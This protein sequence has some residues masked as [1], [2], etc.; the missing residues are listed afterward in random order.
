M[1]NTFNKRPTKIAPQV[2][3]NDLLLLNVG[4][5][6]RFHPNWTNID[7]VSTVPEVI[8]YNILTGLPFEANIFDAVYH[9]HVLEHLD[10]TAAQKLM[11]ECYRVLKPGGIIRVVLPDLAYICRRYLQSLDEVL[12]DPRNPIAAEH[13]EWALMGMIDQLVRTR[14]GGEIGAFLKRGQFLD[15]DFIRSSGTLIEEVRGNQ[16]TSRSTISRLRR[17]TPRKL[18]RYLNQRLMMRFMGESY[19]EVAFRRLGEVHKW[20]YDEYSLSRLMTTVGL[21]DTEFMTAE[22]SKIPGWKSYYLDAEANGNIRKPHS[23]FAEALK[24]IS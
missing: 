11:Q 3:T 13:Y 19:R 2:A 1:K 6:T 22:T 9:S 12:A 10:R 24:P 20:M 4:C 15:E 7:L 17:A 5:G 8:Q 18:I 16:P 21:V 23:L 14:S